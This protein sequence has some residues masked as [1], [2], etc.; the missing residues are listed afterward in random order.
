[1][2]LLRVRIR[3]IIPLLSLILMLS[4]GMVPSAQAATPSVP[5]SELAPESDLGGTPLRPESTWKIEPRTGEFQWSYPFRVPPVAGGF[6]PGVTL[7]YGSQ[8]ISGRSAP[9]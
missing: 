4:P 9:K 3:P 6:R 5:I 2:E 1:M 7:T 8:R